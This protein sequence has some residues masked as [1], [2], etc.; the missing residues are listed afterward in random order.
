MRQRYIEIVGSSR[1]GPNFPVRVAT[2][3]TYFLDLAGAPH[4]GGATA[5]FEAEIRGEKG[6]TPFGL[7]PVALARDEAI[8]RGPR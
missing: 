8:R 5:R 1:A 7:K 6:G 4:C 3:R 2:K